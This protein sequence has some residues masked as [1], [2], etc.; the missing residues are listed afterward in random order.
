MIRPA[1]YVVQRDDTLYSIA[2][3]FGIDFRTLSDWNRLPNPNVINVGQR[4][5]LRAPVQQL[6]KSAA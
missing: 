4:L 3:R 6:S 5:R 2:W 1:S